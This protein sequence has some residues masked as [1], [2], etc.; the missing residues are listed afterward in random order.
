[1]SHFKT[2]TI[3]S[4]PAGARPVLEGANK[5]LGF[6]PNLYANM[7]ESPAVLNAYVALGDL[8]EKSSLNKTEQQVVSLSASVVNGCEFCVAAHSVIAKNM[9]GVDAAIVDAIR[10]GTT[11]PDAQLEALAVFTRAVVTERGW[12]SGASTD[13]FIAAGFSAQQALDVVLGVTMK[14]LSNYTNHL[15]ETEVNSQFAGEIW[16][17]SAA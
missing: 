15:T 14:T 16:S 6:V 2:H 10:S 9:V 3:D 17:R 4:A 13:A 11:L 8:F 1:M 7:A 5:A 12:V